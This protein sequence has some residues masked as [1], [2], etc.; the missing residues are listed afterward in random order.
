V[1][2]VAPSA[3]AADELFELE[4]E[5]TELTAEAIKTS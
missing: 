4:L 3:L 2:A 5:P 1:G